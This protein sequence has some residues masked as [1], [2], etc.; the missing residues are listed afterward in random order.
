M[1]AMAWMLAAAV[2]VGADGAPPQG[3][4]AVDPPKTGAELECANL[5]RD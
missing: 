1:A 2:V 5:S 4:V 3:W